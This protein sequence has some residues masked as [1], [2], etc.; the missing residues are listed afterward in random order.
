MSFPWWI[1]FSLQGEKKIVYILLIFPFP[2]I[3]HD[4]SFH[5]CEYLFH[6]FDDSYSTF[7]PTSSAI[8]RWWWLRRF[9]WSSEMKMC[10]TRKI[11]DVGRG[12]R[13][14]EANSVKVKLWWRR[15]RRWRREILK[16]ENAR[17][18][19]FS[20]KESTMRGSEG[21]SRIRRKK[22]LKASTTVK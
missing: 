7:A 2:F 3:N 11:E 9:S 1:F 21:R 4:G 13:K 20:W 14:S 18:L 5:S 19:W 16:R 15:Y 17:R 10:F 22:S 8:W 12:R 6:L